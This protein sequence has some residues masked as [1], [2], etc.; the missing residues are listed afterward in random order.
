VI[1]TPAPAETIQQHLQQVLASPLFRNADRQTS[2]LRFVVEHALAEP[3]SGLK[4]FSI[5]MAVYNRRSDYDPKVDPIVRVEASRLRARLREYY[6]LA[7]DAPLRIE[8]PK[9]SYLPQ[10]VVR[11]RQPVSVATRN[12]PPQQRTT[13]AVAPFRNLGTDPDDQY[14][15]DGLTDELLHHFMLSPVLQVLA[16]KA[17][18]PTSDLLATH[19]AEGSVRRVGNRVRISLH[20]M[21]LTTA[22]V[23]F[24]SV[25]QHELTDVFAVQEEVARSAAAEITGV[26]LAATQSQTS[27]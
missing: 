21:E 24:S 7:P 26:L 25:Y 20:V 19:L 23:V 12:A 10:F 15:C 2:F 3:D 11:H 27:H 22:R 17:S 6:D 1:V 5:A 9:G 13:L 14:F 18:L 4:E 8:L 16:R